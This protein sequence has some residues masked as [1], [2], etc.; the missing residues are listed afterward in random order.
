MLINLSLHVS[1]PND[2]KE[3]D[4]LTRTQSDLTTKYCFEAG[5]GK[6]A[7]KVKRQTLPPKVLVEVHIVQKIFYWST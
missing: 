4:L 1:A 5:D 7:Q 6:I 2:C 3:I